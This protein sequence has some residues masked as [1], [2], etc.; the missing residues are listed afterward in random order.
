MSSSQPSAADNKQSSYH[1][2]NL[3]QALI[4]AAWQELKAKGAQNMSLR[5]IARIAGV[6]QTAPYRHFDDK[7]HLLVAM[8]QETHLML[9]DAFRQAI[10]SEQ[11][12]LHNIYNIGLSYV[13]FARTNPDRYKLIFGPSVERRT[14]YPELVDAGQQS[15]GVVIS[16]VQLLLSQPTCSL[17][18]SQQNIEMTSYNLWASVHGLASVVID[19]LYQGL[20]SI[21]DLD[22]F[23]E[24]QLKI[25][26]SFLQAT[27]T[28]AE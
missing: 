5:S 15:I 26:M 28:K 6:S 24:Q 17:E 11:D 23:I 16:Q 22:Q 27:Q 12:A 3:K 21:T 19:G 1:H 20:E 18:N 2:G 8:A 10:N 9:A 7:N 4:E 13:Q 25:N 14:E